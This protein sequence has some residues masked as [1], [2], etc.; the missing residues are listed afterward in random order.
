MDKERN[1]IFN[2]IDAV[3]M[4]LFCDRLIC[5]KKKCEVVNIYDSHFSAQISKLNKITNVMRYFEFKL[6]V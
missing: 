2:G 6:V 1:S 3:E 4:S 5:E